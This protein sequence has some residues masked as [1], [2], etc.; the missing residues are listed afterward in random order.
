MSLRP[1]PFSVRGYPHAP[2]RPKS[3]AAVGS[4]SA[5]GS[6]PAVRVFCIGRN[7]AGHARELANPPPRSPVV[8]I[9]PASA[10]LAAGEPIPF[11]RHGRELHHEAE[12]VV[13]IG[14]AGRVHGPDQAAA[15]IDAFTLGLDLT[16]RDVQQR[17]KQQGLP[18][19][20]AK[21]F[22]ASA[23]V[24]AFTDWDASL[25]LQNIEFQCRVNGELRQSGNTADMLF[26]VA[27]LLVE[28]SRVWTLQPGDLLYTGTPAGVGPLR[29][30]DSIEL[31]SAATGRFDWTVAA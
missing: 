17:L 20:L 5:P 22:D 10:L 14:R 1:S 6:S 15:F 13:R 2:A 4:L 7:Y 28:L 11:P 18:W 25:D 8:F 12:L 24:G 16:L 21:A 29:V 26:P 19:E 3:D 9:K 27:R 30:G 31:A 23:P